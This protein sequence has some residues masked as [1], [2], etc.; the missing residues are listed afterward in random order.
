VIAGIQKVVPT[1]STEHGFGKN[2]AFPFVKMHQH[3]NGMREIARHYARAHPDGIVEV[4]GSIP[5]GS[6]NKSKGLV[7]DPLSGDIRN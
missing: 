1:C 7:S 2:P 5:V 6:A 3:I 4:T